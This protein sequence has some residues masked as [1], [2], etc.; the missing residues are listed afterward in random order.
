MVATFVLLLVILLLIT[1]EAIPQELFEYPF[2]DVRAQ[3]VYKT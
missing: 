1:A 3:W 2:V